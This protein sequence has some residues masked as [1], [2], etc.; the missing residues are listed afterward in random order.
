MATGGGTADVHGSG[1]MA[2]YN[3]LALGT[4]KFYL[5][6]IDQ[7]AAGKTLEIDL[8]DPGDVSGGAWLR[9]LD[10]DGGVYNPATFSWS[11]DANASS[12]HTSGSSTTCIQANGGSTTGLTPPSGC[13]NAT[14]GGS[15]F[16]NSWIKILI[17][18]PTTY[19]SAGLTPVRR[20][21][22]GLVEDRVHRRP[23]AATSRP[24]KSTS[25]ATRSTSSSRDRPG[26][27][28]ARQPHDIGAVG[29]AGGSSMSGIPTGPSSSPERCQAAPSNAGSVLTEGP[30][31]PFLSRS[32]AR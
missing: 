2:A 32:T 20:E 15:F 26:G 14:S 13:P 25:S 6:Q 29:A 1:R 3:N 12:G 8:F 18:L 23:A 10:P 27:T 22:G 24:G 11:A 9:V 4:Q 28:R 5:A 31:D 21:P 17:P 19:G 16:Q 7:T 30:W